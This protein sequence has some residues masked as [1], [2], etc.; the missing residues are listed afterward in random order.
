MI[1]VIRELT[2]IAMAQLMPPIFADDFALI[3][4]VYGPKL[5]VTIFVQEY[6]LENVAFEWPVFWKLALVVGA[7]K[8]HF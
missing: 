3:Y 6:G 1:Y 5:A 7:V 4:L 8:T 2:R